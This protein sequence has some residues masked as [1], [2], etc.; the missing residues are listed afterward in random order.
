MLCYVDMPLL[1]V[2]FADAVLCWHAIV[3]SCLCW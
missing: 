3:T 2:A 1:Q